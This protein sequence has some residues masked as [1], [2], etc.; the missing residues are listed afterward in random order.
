M[1]SSVLAYAV[2]GALHAKAEMQST[3][4]VNQLFQSDAGGVII[5]IATAVKL[6]DSPQGSDEKPGS[7]ATVPAKTSQ[8][9][10]LNVPVYTNVR[11][12]PD[13]TV[14]SVGETFDV[15]VWINNVTGMAG[16]EIK[17]F[18]NKT[19]IRCLK[20]HVNT[21]SEW[22]G[23]PFDWFNKTVSDVDPN[24]VYTAW[25]FG[26]GLDD[27]YNS[28]Y[29]LYF[30]AEC[31][32]PRGG[33][34]HNTFTGSLPIVTLSFQALQEGSTSLNLWDWEPTGDGESSAKCQSIKIGTRDAQP[35]PSSVFKGFVEVKAL[36]SETVELTRRHLSTLEPID[37]DCS[38]NVD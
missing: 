23:V 34:Y 33:N 13:K 19:V 16:W 8:M 22:G 1:L 24:A 5:D 10:P 21:P 9:Q 35:I 14:V 18:W 29:G 27:G 11:V 7:N 36:E 30:K 3:R 26:P 15:N 32:G 37:G 17:L 28:S 2:V 25:M 4:F 12:V 38:N 6:G 31:F 20:A